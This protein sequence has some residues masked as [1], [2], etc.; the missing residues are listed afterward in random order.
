[1]LIRHY[2]NARPL[3]I[4]GTYGITLLVSL[5][6]L[7]CLILA[8]ILAGNIFNPHFIDGEVKGQRC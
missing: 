3:L 6:V 1:M 2:Y 5:H 7:L 8:T 4:T